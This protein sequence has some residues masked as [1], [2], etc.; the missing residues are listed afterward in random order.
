[1]SLIKKVIVFTYSI[2]MKISK[3]TGLGIRVGANNSNKNALVNFYSLKAITISG[4]EIRFERYQHKK[5]LIVNL[6]SRCGY[7]PQY[8]ELEQLH[9][10]N[11]NVII[12]GFPSNN[13]GGQE[14]GSDQE[15]A[16]FCSINYGVTFQLFK[17]NDVKGK[18]KQPV[19]RWLSDAGKNGWNN[20]EPR[21]NFYK[22]LIDE[23]GNLLNVFSSSVSPLHITL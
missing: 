16:K 12:L 6:A 18:N 8:N 15:I 11:K 21:W 13:F 9:Q 19:Y 20:E 4:E 2:R 23:N 14:P 17:K 22:Y 7:T 1:M 5:I 10:Q 3:L